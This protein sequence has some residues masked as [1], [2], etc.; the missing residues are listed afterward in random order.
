MPANGHTPGV[1][2]RG[3]DQANADQRERRRRM[4][5][6][7][8]VRSRRYSNNR[9][10]AWRICQRQCDA[11]RTYFVIGSSFSQRLRLTRFMLVC[12]RTTGLVSATSKLTRLLSRRASEDAR[13]RGGRY[14]SCDQCDNGRHRNHDPAQHQS[15]VYHELDCASTKSVHPEVGTARC[16]VRTPQRG[17]FIEPPV[18][19]CFSA[20]IL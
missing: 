6:E 4:Q 19:V 18:F 2:V 10:R 8:C 20:R 12:S 1:R 13:A 16:A 9:F 3:S 17:V 14:W 15:S 5:I 11:C 7:R